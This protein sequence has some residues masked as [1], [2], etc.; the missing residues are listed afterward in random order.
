[1]IRD[2]STP[3]AFRRLWT[4]D[5]NGG[6]YAELFLISA[7]STI[8]L[9]RAFLAATGYPQ[10]GGKSQLHIA[11]ML[12]GGLLMVIALTLTFM[13]WSDVWKTFN[14]VI[15]GIGFGLFIDELGKFITKDNDYFFSPTIAILYMIF[16]LFFVLSR[17]VSRTKTFSPFEIRMNALTALE[18]MAIGRLSPDERAQALRV[19]DQASEDDRLA[20]HA[21]L[22]LLE[23]WAEAK[24]HE[25]FYSRMRDRLLNFYR[26]LASHPAFRKVLIALFTIDAVMSIVSIPLA[27]YAGKNEG[28]FIAIGTVISAVMVAVCNGFG[29][30]LLLK[31]NQLLALKAFQAGVLISILF[32]QFF[33]FAAS[34][35]AAVGGLFVQLLLFGALHYVINQMELDNRQLAID[36]AAPKAIAAS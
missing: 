12:W 29:V 8:L 26:R 21:R 17:L 11:H 36:E 14:A 13:L 27:I 1:M 16:I 10:V 35:L 7:V 32:V 23:G 25:G 20:Q 2:E 18:R 5:I 24:D 22:A 33:N 15:G 34:Q 3:G 9:V 6:H 31:G 4:R 30:Y 28:G 19:L